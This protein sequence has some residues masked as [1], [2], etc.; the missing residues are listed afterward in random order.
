MKTFK[1]HALQFAIFA[2][3]MSGSAFDADALL[4]TELNTDEIPTDYIPVPAGEFQAEFGKP[5]IS[6][7]EKDG[8]PW[9]R[10]AIPCVILDQEVC[11]E[12]N[13]EKPTVRFETF[14]DLTEAGGLDFATNKNV[15]LGQAFEAAGLSGTAAITALEGARILVKVK[16]EIYQDRPIAKVV[17]VAAL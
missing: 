4:H 1:S 5:S 8:K 14:L 10:L 7:G 2:A 17:G 12:M 6:S 3:A 13:V 9:A 16:Q 11:E 15:K